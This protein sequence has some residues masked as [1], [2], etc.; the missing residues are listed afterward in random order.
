MFMA[1]SRTIESAS[2]IGTPEEM[3]VPRVRMVRATMLFSMSEPMTGMYSFSLSRMYAPV[4]FRRMSLNVSQ[5]ETGTS[6]ITYQYFTNHREVAISMSVIHGSFILKS[7]KIF[8]NFGMMK[9]MM[10]LRI[11]TATVMTTHG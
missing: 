8:S 11:S 1:V 4:L 9:I 6:G 10:K 3:S 5:I 2:R 7:S